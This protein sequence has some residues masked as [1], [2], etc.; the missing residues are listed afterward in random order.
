MD[1]ASAEVIK[2]SREELYEQIWNVPTTKLA[3]S[4]GLSDVALGKICRK[5][6]PAGGRAGGRV[7]HHSNSPALDW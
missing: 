3:R 7:Y 1:M 6:S 2:L 4:Y 5:H